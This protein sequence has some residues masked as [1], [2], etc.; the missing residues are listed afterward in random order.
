MLLEQI[1]SEMIASLKSGDKL[2]TETLRFL[3]SAVKKYEI[4][5][6]LPGSSGKLTDEDVLKIIRKQVKTHDE[7]I[8]A[9]T[10]GARPEL[11]EKEK[12]ELEILKKYL[13]IEMSEEEIRKL[14]K[15]VVGSG[16]TQFGPVMGMVMK[17][18]AG[19]A[20][21]DRVGKIVGEEL[22]K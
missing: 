22:Q 8:V 15:L 1:Q 21:G 5:T 13:P 14:V 2:R 17:Q 19:R 9:F 16:Q 20:G 7:S 10:K 18:V 6:Y 3:I 4:D 11:A 12:A